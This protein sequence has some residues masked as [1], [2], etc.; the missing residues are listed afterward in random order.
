MP[1]QDPVFNSYDLC[2]QFQKNT[3]WFL[4]P[5][6]KNRAKYAVGDDGHD[7][8]CKKYTEDDREEG[9]L[10]W[11]MQETRDEGTCPCAGTRQWDTD[12]EHESPEIIFLNRCLI[13]FYLG[14]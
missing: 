3:G 4:Y 9:F 10:S 7:N 1:L 13:L 8:G 14:T 12:E 2:G 11:H 5:L 6:V